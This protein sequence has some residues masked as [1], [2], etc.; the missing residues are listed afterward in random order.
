MH[1]C[2][3]RAA[4]DFMLKHA[5]VLLLWWHCSIHSCQ[6][7]T[8][9][10]DEL[11]K[12]RNKRTVS[13]LSLCSV[14]L[15]FLSFSLLYQPLLWSLNTKWQKQPLCKDKMYY[16]YLTINM[17]IQLDRNANAVSEAFSACCA[18]LMDANRVSLCGC[19]FVT[20]SVRNTFKCFS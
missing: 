8:L 19:V 10:W 20:G 11:Q 2:I 15:H 3:K 17:M 18:P 7:C 9:N 5:F 1:S 4:E 12:S 16:A 6:W 13:C 14:L